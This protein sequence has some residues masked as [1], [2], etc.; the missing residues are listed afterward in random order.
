MMSR[1]S[2]GKIWQLDGLVDGVEKKRSSTAAID[3]SS[4]GAALEGGDGCGKIDLIGCGGIGV[5]WVQEDGW[6]KGWV[7][8]VGIGV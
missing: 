8:E 2:R 7:M 6:M 3:P 1:S 5:S 4:N